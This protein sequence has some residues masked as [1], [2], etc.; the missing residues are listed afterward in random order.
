MQETEKKT[1]TCISSKE[2]IFEPATVLY[3]HIRQRPPEL[4]DSN[5][6]LLM[7]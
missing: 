3:W 6:L 4:T 2:R 7:A 1:Q 5:N